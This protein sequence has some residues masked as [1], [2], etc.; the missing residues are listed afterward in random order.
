MSE[1]FDRVVQKVG[2]VLHVER[3]HQEDLA[4]VFGVT[5]RSKYLELPQGTYRS[6]A[7]LIYERSSSAL[8]DIDQ[9]ARIAIY[10]YLIGNCDNHL[11]NLSVLYDKNGALRLAPAYDMLCT[12]FFERYSREMGRR[13]GSVR[14]IDKVTA[15]DFLLLADEIG[16]GRRRMKRLCASMARAVVEAVVQAGDLLESVLEGAS[17][18]AEDLVGDMGPRIAVLA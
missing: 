14:A 18:A 8:A 10:D 9:L 7:R 5:S 6:I 2:N 17:F 16:M 12:T 3:L 11:K 15:D 13:L 1:R 4:Q